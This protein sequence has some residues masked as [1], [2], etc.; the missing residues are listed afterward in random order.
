MHEVILTRPVAHVAPTASFVAHVPEFEGQ[1]LHVSP[2]PE[3]LIPSLYVSAGHGLQ[4]PAPS[5]A[6]LP[7][8][9]GAHLQLVR[10]LIPGV[11][12]VNPFVNTSAENVPSVNSL[13]GLA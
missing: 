13:V 2:A 6:A 3:V 5:D 1:V 12:V 8:W 9:P 11:K 10:L 7:Q 4:V